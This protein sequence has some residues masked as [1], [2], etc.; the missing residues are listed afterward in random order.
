MEEAIEEDTARNLVSLKAMAEAKGDDRINSVSK[1]TDYQLDPRD[2]YIKPGLNVRMPTLAL[3]KSI[4]VL[5]Q[6]LMN[7]A[8]F[9]AIVVFVENNRV[10]VL[11]GHRRTAAY[12]LAISWGLEVKAV[13][14]IPFKGDE[15]ERNAFIASSSEGMALT[16]LEHG[17]VWLRQQNLGWTT[18]QIALRANRSVAHVGNGI[19][20]AQANYDVQMLVAENKVTAK[21]AIRYLRS[22]G[23]ITGA[24]L[25]KVIEENSGKRVT[26][27]TIYGKGIPAAASKQVRQSLGALSAG[28]TAETRERVLA[29]PD[30]EIVEVPARQL[31]DLLAAHDAIFNTKRG[32]KK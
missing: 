13:R 21:I 15:A 30:D 2:L 31:R 28:F 27:K 12:L 4:E 25:L 11:D 20:L 32:R 16:L 5:A 23:S 1:V 10:T 26:D 14:V 8:Q 22:H 17:K 7:G 18:A 24:M 3:K 19:T 6:A 9:P 29:A